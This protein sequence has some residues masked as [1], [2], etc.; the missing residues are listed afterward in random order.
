MPKDNDYLCTKVKMASFTESST[1]PGTG[2]ERMDTMTSIIV[3][4]LNHPGEW[5][6]SNSSKHRLTL[7]SV[8]EKR[9]YAVKRILKTSINLSLLYQQPSE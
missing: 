7:Y 8:S 4:V 1:S 2:L 9:E 3:Y 6:R 5:L